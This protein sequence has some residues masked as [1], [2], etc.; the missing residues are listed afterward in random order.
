MNPE[1]KAAVVVLAVDDETENADLF[2]RA[3]AKRSDL[4]TL[5]AFSPVEALSLLRSNQVDILL[6]DHRMPKM[7]GVQLLERVR[8]LGQQPVAI[9]VTAYPEEPEVKKAQEKGLV[10][11]IVAKPWKTEDLMLAIDFATKHRPQQKK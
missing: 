6:V 11:C 9:M 1:T 10:Q 8:L 4:K 3:L 7:T 5:V 2:R